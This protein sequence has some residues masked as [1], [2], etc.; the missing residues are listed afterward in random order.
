MPED[1]YAQLE[2]FQNGKLTLIELRSLTADMGQM[3]DEKS[4]TI[5]LSLLR[6]DDPITRYNAVMALAFD[7]GVQSA[8]P[9]LTKMLIDDPDE[10]CRSA[11]A[12]ALGQLLQNT[13]DSAA[14]KSL[15]FAS[16]H[17]PDEIVRRSAYKSALIV[18]GVSTEEHLALL[19]DESLLVDIGRI[20]SMLSSAQNIDA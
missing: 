17:D 6:N 8:L 20:Q 16:L 1:A 12:A 7:R 10:D 19:R 9:F 5:L 18:G 3:N 4:E 15:A 14:I 2:R 13:Q 11:A